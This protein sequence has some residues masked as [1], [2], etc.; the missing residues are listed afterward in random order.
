MTKQSATNVQKINVD[1]RASLRSNGT[2]RFDSW[3]RH[4]DDPNGVW[5]SGPI[6][7]PNGPDHY[8]M[9]FDLDDK[10]GRDLEFYQNPA[11]AMYVNVGS[12][13]QG[14]GNGGG[15]I[16]F[17]TVTNGKKKLTIKDVNQ[18]PPCNLH[19]MLR[20]EG[21]ANG[22]CPPYEYDPEIRNGGGGQLI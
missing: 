2:V 16:D 8:R 14:P 6:D 13:P 12:C 1:V 5:R 4:E 15:Q 7:L 20:F 21:A 3:W 9:E 17:E 10:S 19:Y 22:A 11:D 18:D